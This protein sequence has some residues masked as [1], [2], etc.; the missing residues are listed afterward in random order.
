MLAIAAGVSA[1][2]RPIAVTL[3]VNSSLHPQPGQAVALKAKAGRVPRGDDLLIRGR[4]PGRVPFKV[5]VCSSSPCFASWKQRG[6]GSVSFQALL[7]RRGHAATVLGRSKPV[8]ILWEA[9]SSTPPAPPPSVSPPPSGQPPPSGPPRPSGPPQPGHYGGTTEQGTTISFDVDSG[10]ASVSN[11]QIAQVTASC[12][13]P[14]HA[15]A[16]PWA[17]AGP[18]SVQPDGKFSFS[19][20]TSDGGT[21]SLSGSL[22]GDGSVT[23]S[24]VIDVPP[25]TAFKATFKCTSGT[26]GWSA[27]Q[28]G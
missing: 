15:F 27:K 13:P 10:G 6:A 8:T 25:I 9:V 19:G 5:K 17:I 21:G 4:R 3:T 12:E 23:G 28:G 11:V 16:G 14:A 22:G 20:G 26:V 18:I 2:S 24:F 7:I 1:A